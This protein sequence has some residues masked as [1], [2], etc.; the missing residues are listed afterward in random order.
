MIAYGHKLT[1]EHVATLHEM[2]GLLERGYDAMIW[3]LEHV[4]EIR[5]IRNAETAEASI[6]AFRNACRETELKTIESKGDSYFETVFYL[7][8]TDELERMGDSGTCTH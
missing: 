8:I 5:D 4:H 6:N 7:N 1:P 2:T 3:N